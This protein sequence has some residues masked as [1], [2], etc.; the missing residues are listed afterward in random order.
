[1]KLA[2]IEAAS[3]LRDPRLGIQMATLGVAPALAARIFGG[4]DADDRPGRA[5]ID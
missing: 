2:P 4:R 3:F 1:L 5:A